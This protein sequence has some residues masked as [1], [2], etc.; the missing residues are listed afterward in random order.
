MGIGTVIVFLQLSKYS[1]FEITCDINDMHFTD[2]LLYLWRLSLF[3]DINYHALSVNFLVRC[4]CFAFSLPQ[5][6]PKLIPSVLSL[7]K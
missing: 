4:Q 1:T 6:S 7:N 3:D 2:F 5:F